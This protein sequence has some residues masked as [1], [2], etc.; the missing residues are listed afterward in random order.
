MTTFLHNL[1]NIKE[2]P[3]KTAVIFSAILHL[4]PHRFKS[5]REPC[6]LSFDQV[7]QSALM[8]LHYPVASFFQ[9]G[10]SQPVAAALMTEYINTY[11]LFEPPVYKIT[12]GI[13]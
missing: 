7:A 3:P 4:A 10:W 5:H 11:L 6:P 13:G 12:D 8:V 2:N 9:P 1:N